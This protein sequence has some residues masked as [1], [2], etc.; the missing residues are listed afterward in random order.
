MGE[1][2][3]FLSNI[4]CWANCVVDISALHDLLRKTIQDMEIEEAQKQKARHDRG[5]D[6]SHERV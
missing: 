4:A 1:Y 3:G 6:D 5:A 2:A